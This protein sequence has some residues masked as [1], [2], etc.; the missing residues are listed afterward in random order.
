MLTIQR[1]EKV[2]LLLIREMAI[3]SWTVAYAS[4]LSPAQLSFMLEHIYAIP[5]LEKQMQELQQ[6]YLLKRFEHV[7]GFASFSIIDPSKQE[8]KLNKFYLLP[9]FKGKGYGKLF[10]NMM[11]HQMHICGGRKIFLNV[12]RNNPAVSFYEHCGFK[13]IR[14]EDVPIGIFWMNDF[15]MEIQL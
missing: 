5:S 1:A 9:T 3:E 13:I 7:L 4:I 11:L 12:N 8:V 14:Q 6:F 15:V 2:D 10:M